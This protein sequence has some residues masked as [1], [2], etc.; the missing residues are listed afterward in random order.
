LLSIPAPC[1]AEECDE[2]LAGLGPEFDAPA[3]RSKITAPD[4][5]ADFDPETYNPE[6]IA[7]RG[8]HLLDK[9]RAKYGS[10]Q[11]QNSSQAS[12]RPSH[13]FCGDTLR[14]TLACERRHA[15][16][17]EPRPLEATPPHVSTASL[18][19]VLTP[20][21]RDLLA[22]IKGT[23]PHH[24]KR[25]PAWEHSDEAIK[26]TYAHRA[27]NEAGGLAFTLNLSPKTQR[28]V[29]NSG[30]G[31]LRKKI[32]R[33]FKAA[34]DGHVPE[35]WFVFDTTPQG[36]LHIHGG[37]II[38]A[39]DAALCE[40]ALQA[41]GGWKHKWACHVERRDDDEW[42]LYSTRNVSKT[43]TPGTR[44]VMSREISRRAREL[45]KASKAIS[46]AYTPRNQR[47][48]RVETDK[49]LLIEQRLKLALQ[50]HRGAK[51]VSLAI[52]SHPGKNPD[53]M[54]TYVPDHAYKLTVAYGLQH[55]LT[56]TADRLLLDRAYL[57]P[58]ARSRLCKALRE[59]PLRFDQCD[60]KNSIRIALGEIADIW[61]NGISID[62]SPR[63]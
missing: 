18:P 62:R 19:G 42:A 41:A 26:A 55:A 22:A 1:T 25:L 49:S 5:L 4:L 43:T 6:P 9:V 14:K 50:L 38:P 24:H 16:A 56:G 48:K 32:W 51:R 21:T 47:R 46:D 8:P 39:E 60:P 31:A 28:Q 40:A 29:E 10:R 7:P 2:I 12:S 11:F 52:R 57:S 59:D 63:L 33:A 34:F 45:H 20:S 53:P 44:L 15:S 54:Q 17:P 27:V 61:P 3:P 30:A 35:M 23:T 58:D 13:R 36:R 37:V